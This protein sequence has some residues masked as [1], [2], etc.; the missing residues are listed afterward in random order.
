MKD[1]Y[2]ILGVPFDADQKAIKAAYR[3]LA[4]RYHPD[5]QSDKHST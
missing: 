2:R 3:R 1:Y 4:R 5:T